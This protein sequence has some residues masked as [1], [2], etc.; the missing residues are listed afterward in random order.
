MF[1]TKV[2]RHGVIKIK[3]FHYIPTDVTLYTNTVPTLLIQ[4]LVSAYSLFLS[5]FHGEVDLIFIEIN[6]FAELQH[7]V[8]GNAKCY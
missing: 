1:D 5:R 3:L 4:L 8:F 2:Y 6:H 7:I